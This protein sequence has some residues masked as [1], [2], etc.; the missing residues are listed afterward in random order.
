MKRFDYPLSTALAVALMGVLY[1]PTQLPAALLILALT[2]WAFVHF[3]W[4]AS[5]WLQ[6]NTL[7][8][9]TRLDAAFG[10]VGILV[11]SHWLSPPADTIVAAVALGGL[12]ILLTLLLRRLEP[13][14]A[15]GVSYGALI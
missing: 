7:R 10:L 11:A 12:A 1:P 3:G 13:N 6:A 5:K 9:A 8:R 14:P 2:V 4:K 15:R